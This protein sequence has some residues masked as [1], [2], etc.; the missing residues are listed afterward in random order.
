MPDTKLEHYPVIGPLPQP[1][2]EHLVLL[3][4]PHATNG[5]GRH[6]EIQELLG[7]E[8][9]SSCAIVKTL[10]ENE[11]TID[12]LAKT[13]GHLDT[14]A[15][16][17]D[18]VTIVAVGGD[19]TQDN[20]SQAIREA[21]L[22]RVKAKLAAAKA[23]NKSDTA[24]N[25]GTDG[26]SLRELIELGRPVEVF[27]LQVTVAAEGG[28]PIVRETM[29]SAGG[30]AS[31][32]VSADVNKPGFRKGNW[33]SEAGVVW[34]AIRRARRK[35]V[36]LVDNNIG[37]ENGPLTD[38]IIGAGRR[39]AGGAIRFSRSSLADPERMS[40]ALS[41]RSWLSILGGLAARLAGKGPG[42]HEVDGGAIQLTFRGLEQIEIG[43]EII[44][45][46]QRPNKEQLVT[47]SVQRA[48]P[49]TALV[50]DP[51]AVRPSKPKKSWFGSRSPAPATA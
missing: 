3:Y 4:N 47:V 5:N 19:G 6:K 40:M 48:A 34:R 13:L 9:W 7:M 30:G 23:G 29:H 12:A 44:Q 39:I 32:L 22:S 10:P 15:N 14:Y 42:Y 46:Q 49:V 31:G 20:G 2:Q 24:F 1:T 26:C 21:K 25:L 18:E 27:P 36:E 16:I 28:K 38:F 8:R 51:K 33:L 11:L 37:M 17:G 41:R 50:M 35:P 45:T 43:G